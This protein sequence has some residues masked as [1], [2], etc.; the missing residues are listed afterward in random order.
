MIGKKGQRIISYND[1]NFETE[2]PGTCIAFRACVVWTGRRAR[3]LLR[4]RLWEEGRKPI[5]LEQHMRF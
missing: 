2:K 1:Y 5:S 3:D 4:F